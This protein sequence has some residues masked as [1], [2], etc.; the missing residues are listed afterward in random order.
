MSVG[1]IVDQDFSSVAEGGVMDF[2]FVDFDGDACFI[3]GF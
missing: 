3:D 1:L 2:G